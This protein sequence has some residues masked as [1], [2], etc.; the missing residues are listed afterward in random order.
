MSSGRIRVGIGGWTYE[1][2][3]ESFYPADLSR[4]RELQYASR[5]VTAIEINGT[6][7]RLQKPS[8]FAKW[9]D[10]TPGDFIFSLKALRYVVNRQ[11]LAEA[12]RYVER[13]LQSGV[14]ELG[15]K[16]GPI[17]W[18]LAPE[19]RFER[20]DLEPF[21]DA[22]PEQQDG[23]RLRHVLEVRHETFDCRDFFDIA[24]NRGMA[25]AF[26]DSQKQPSLEPVS[27]PFVYA[28]LKRSSASVE[29][30]YSSADLEAWAAK[31]RIWAQGSRDVFVFFIDGA[32]ERAPAA[33]RALLR[34]IS[35]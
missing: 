30:G 7:Y 19:Y 17:L 8:T 35:D 15:D 33:A 24:S 29:N 9:R 23:L 2:W 34:L 12:G 27:A 13:F 26:T 25:I 28:R 10:A 20:T 14:A 31:A 16:L 3:R 6:F 11:T 4:A 5:H 32:K 21:L 1:P 22:L 18:Q